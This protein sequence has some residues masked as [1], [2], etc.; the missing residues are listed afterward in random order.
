MAANERTGV[1]TKELVDKGAQGGALGGCASIGPGTGVGG[2]AATDVADGNGAGINGLAVCTLITDR[3]TE[4]DAAIEVDQV[5][6]TDTLKVSSS[7][8][9]VHIGDGDGTACGGVSAMYD[10]VLDFL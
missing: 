3:T 10:D 4:V 1:L 6:V 9:G 5:V 8:P 7:M 2:S